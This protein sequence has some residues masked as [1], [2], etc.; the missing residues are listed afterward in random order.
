MH[1]KFIAAVI[2][3]TIAITGFAAAPARADGDD[4]ARALAGIAALA[5]I[6]R[7]IDKRNDERAVARQQHHFQPHKPQYHAPAPIKPRPLPPQVSRKLLPEQCLRTFD[8]PH[9]QTHAFGARCL[10]RNYTFAE[11][12]PRQC[13]EQV[14]TRQGTGWAYNARC[15]R[16]QGY[17]TARF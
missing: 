5:L 7:A 8:G 15:L 9:G 10:S 1:R 16:R 13:A 6:A 3:A 17:Q 14:W 4:V 12:L 11:S 2:A